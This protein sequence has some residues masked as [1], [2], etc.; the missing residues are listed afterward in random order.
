M[1]LQVQLSARPGTSM[2]LAE[3]PSFQLD[4]VVRNV[5]ASVGDPGIGASTLW[6]D[7]KPAKDWDFILSSGPRDRRWRAL[8]SQEE[9]DFGY[10]L[11]DRFFSSPGV[12]VLVLE[13][14]GVRSP[15][16]TVHVR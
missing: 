1:L 15:L 2:T 3:L 14:S 6:L 8:R 13:V 10:R 7:G 9:V 11:G 4:A 5:G 16:L 12:Y